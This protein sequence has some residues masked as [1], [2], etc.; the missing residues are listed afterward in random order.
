MEKKEQTN[1]TK[2]EN[3]DKYICA[4]NNPFLCYRRHSVLIEV[5]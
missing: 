4:E 5:D 3:E 2:G 1:R